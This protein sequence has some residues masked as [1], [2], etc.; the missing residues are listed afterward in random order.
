MYFGYRQAEIL[1]TEG[2]ITAYR[3]SYDLARWVLQYSSHPASQVYPAE[4]EDVLTFQQGLAP[5]STFVAVWDKPIEAAEEG[6]FSATTRPGNQQQARRRHA[7]AY[8]IEG[9]GGS[10]RDSRS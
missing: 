2:Y 6:G 8:F 5:K 7:E 3:A 4:L 9:P 10:F 1:R